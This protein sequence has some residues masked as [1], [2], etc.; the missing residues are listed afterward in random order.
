MPLWPGALLL[1]ISLSIPTTSETQYQFTQASYNVSIP[2]NSLRDTLATTDTKMGMYGVDAN[3][4]Y[5]IVE[6]DPNNHFRVE[7]RLV[8]DFWFLV[9]RARTFD[10]NRE[11]KD[12]YRLTVNAT[13]DGKV[14]QTTLVVVNI[15]DT[16]DLGP[17]FFSSEYTATVPED[18]AVHSSIVTVFAED[19]DLGVNGEV[20]YSFPEVTEHFAVH[21]VTGVIT[22]VKPLRYSERSVYDLKVVARD[23]GVVDPRFRE[24]PFDSAMVRVVVTQVNLH[25]PK[26]YVYNLPEL[27][28]HSYVDVYAVVR[29]IDRDEGI[30]GE[31]QSLEI[32]D[33]D[34]DGHF[35][36]T[37]AESPTPGVKGEEFNIEIL[38]LADKNSNP[39][40]YNLTLRAIDKGTPSRTTYISVPFKLK[41][42]DYNKAVFD[43]EVYEVD[44]SENTPVNSSIIRLKIDE[45][46]NLDSN[47]VLLEIVGGN[48]AGEFR[49][50]SKTGV[51]YTAV[52]LDAEL[53]TFYTLTVS[54]IDHGAVR[55]RKQSSAKVK[56]HVVDMN[57]NDPQFE[58]PVM[59]V[60]INENEP[61]GAST[62]KVTA[63]DKDSGENA[64]IS[65]SIA[66]LNA[67]PFEIDHFTGLVRTTK[68]L[69][70][71]SMRRK[72]NLYIRASDWGTPYRRQ[73]EMKLRVRIRDINDN[74]PLFEKT[75]CVGHLPRQV[76]IDT[77]IVTLSAIDLDA[78]NIITYRI[79]SGNEDGCFRLD[80]TS[81]MLSVACDLREVAT[82]D[83]HINVTA[84]DGTHFADFARVHI[85]LINS[86]RP[87]DF[88]V[89]GDS[90]S[91]D[92]K[93]LGVAKRLT[94]V[95]ALAEKNNGLKSKEEDEVTL[96][97]RYGANVYPPQFI[98]MPNEIEINESVPIDFV[99]MKVKAVDRDLGYN[100]KLIF[101]ITSG[102]E[103][104]TF[105]ID[106]ET[107]ELKVAGYL[108]R[109]HRERYY[110]NI[111]VFDL[112][113]PRL[114]S[115]RIVSIVILDVND[116]APVFD[117]NVASFRIRED[118]PSG[119]EIFQFRASDKDLGENSHIRY[120]IET[121]TDNF[122][123]DS[124]SGM[125]TIADMLDRET[126]S[127][128]ELKIKAIDRA[129][130]PKDP[131]A[132]HSYAVVKVIVEDVNDEVP[133]FPSKS[134]LV[135]IREDLPVGTVVV[136]LDVWDPD[137]DQGGVVK[138]SIIHPVGEIPF[139]IDQETGTIRTTARLDYE[140][141]QMFA[142]VISG[143][144]LGVPALAS[145]VNLTI[146]ITDVNENEHPPKF[147]DFAFS[148]KIRENL[149][150]DSLVTSL[151]A[152]D[153]DS[154]GEDSRISFIIIGGSG[155]GLF[156]IDDKGQIWT[157]AVLD[158]ET[159]SHYW[160]TVLVYDHGVKPLHS[161]AEVY[162]EVEDDN[163]NVPL[164]E[165]ASY[166]GRVVE[167]SPRNTAVLRIL[168]RDADRSD[169]QGT[170]ISYVITA[171]NAAGHFAIN[172][173]GVL[174]TTTDQIDRELQKE[175][176][177]EVTLTDNGVPP[178]SSTVQV[179][180]TVDD[181]NDNSPQF[182][183]TF[184]HIMIPEMHHRDST[185]IIQNEVDVSETDLEFEAL[186][187]G[188]SWRNLD[189]NNLTGY[190]VFRL[191]AKDDDAGVNGQLE[192]YIKSSQGRFNVHPLSGIVYA[193]KLLPANQDYDLL[194][195]KRFF[196]D[197]LSI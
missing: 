90:A 19:A 178:L 20:Y 58:S 161:R 38:K 133:T 89:N 93:D 141:R 100:G 68:V 17:F 111:T 32:V 159:S 71:E 5:R 195:S 165:E 56:I 160:L 42:T 87:R 157:S 67:V 59:D 193:Q 169:R 138:Y 132:L 26:I 167:N 196:Y 114:S 15:I 170:G 60:W 82:S 99:V 96:P 51:L 85:K 185:F 179:I 136:T 131:D 119:F 197:L 118:T 27:T 151:T 55:P 192:Y 34:D 74:K 48:E 84:Y 134:C 33:G 190:P 158:R 8:G 120:E 53:K 10:L 80:V 113:Q 24:K 164:A 194:V 173:N 153:A 97:N 41:E 176:V 101:G 125:L 77:D 126:Q 128:H 40:G 16:N 92:C 145:E 122:A 49:I 154:P 45:R 72:Y 103:D 137:L 112:G 61:A 78:G 139:A 147:G 127:V 110:L 129:S 109:E 12:V 43:R 3:V 50:N 107:G 180:I 149:P 25:G 86:D 31:I 166:E 150:A 184:Y 123:I 29:V 37:K 174:Y 152:T 163:D 44:V 187:T 124:R 191:V 36:I 75:D 57:D 177:L 7:A 11:R 146:E 46:N 140:D 76:P 73:S 135:K 189:I 102:D 64:Y 182:D 143:E 155:L 181:A 70:Y 121:D 130:D 66:N 65:Y 62:A 91:F 117:K 81:G 69:D 14:T 116:N 183:Q 186:F 188:E 21:P 28:E 171:G 95:L 63:K 142:L 18:L 4:S 88:L 1:F 30:N 9:V 79:A 168:A 23:R 94:E 105:T 83:R 115:S 156:N 52:P 148:A 175:Y 98:S 22:L 54:A 6:G 144:D 172:E 35:R 39:G 2:E 108:D 162:I 13:V 104:S 47:F 106:P